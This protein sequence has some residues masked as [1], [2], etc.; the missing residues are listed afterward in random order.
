[1]LAARIAVDKKRFQK[2]LRRKS[3]NILT[4]VDDW[5]ILQ[6]IKRAETFTY[7]LY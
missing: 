4:R 1:M 2:K 7:D 6:F 5:S 3:K